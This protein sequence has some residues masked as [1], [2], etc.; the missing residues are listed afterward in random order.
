MNIKIEDLRFYNEKPSITSI[1]KYALPP[2]SFIEM[3]MQRIADS[4][5]PEAGMAAFKKMMETACMRGSYVHRFFEEY[6]KG[7]VKFY[8]E[9]P[10]VLAYINGAINFLN[11]Y[12]KKLTPKEVDGVK[13]VE[14]PIVGESFAGTADMFCYSDTLDGLGVLDYKTASKAKLDTESLYRYKLQIA[15]N[16]ALYEEKYGDEPIKWGMIQLI[17]DKRKNGIGEQYIV[18]EDELATLKLEFNAHRRKLDRALEGY[19]LSSLPNYLKT[20]NIMAMD[21]KI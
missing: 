20:D 5:D 1:I 6:N 10:V 18:H 9:N 8:H 15:A 12:G 21:R 13:L 2:L 11:S 17:T 14:V 4:D 7:N 3:Y 16:A 19:D